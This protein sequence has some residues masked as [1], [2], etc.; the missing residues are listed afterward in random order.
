MYIEVTQN[1]FS[2]YFNRIR[3]DN[4]SYEG[5]VALFEYLSEFEDVGD[6]RVE[7]DVVALCCEFSE[8]TREEHFDNYND[9]DYAQD[10]I[11]AEFGCDNL[12]VREG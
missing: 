6:T 5:Q 3:P 4:F 10:L 9:K 2:D 12:I 7:L 1:I 11:C 8:T